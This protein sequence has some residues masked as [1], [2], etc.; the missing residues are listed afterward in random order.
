ML[1]LDPVDYYRFREKQELACAQ[2]AADPAAAM[3]HS[4]LAR[5]YRGRIEELLP[6][7]PLPMIPRFRNA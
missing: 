4:E 2:A 5:R 3:I 6:P 7:Y 1:M